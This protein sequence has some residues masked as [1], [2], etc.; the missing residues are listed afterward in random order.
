MSHGLTYRDVEVYSPAVRSVQATG[1]ASPPSAFETPTR[2]P[3]HKNTSTA[4]NEQAVQS[5]RASIVC[6]EATALAVLTCSYAGTTAGAMA[7][8]PAVS[9]T[10]VVRVQRDN[11]SSRRSTVVV[12][13]PK[14]TRVE[15]GRPGIPSTRACGVMYSRL[16]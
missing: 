7:T 4:A 3:E 9:A 2:P 13:S 12:N 8:S 1:S 16:G 14:Q 6:I 10:T 11:G 15:M 5:H